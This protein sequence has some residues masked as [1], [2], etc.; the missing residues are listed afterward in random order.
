MSP[1]IR[2]YFPLTPAQVAQLSDEGRIDAGLVGFAVDDSIRAGD[3]DGDA[4]LWEFLSL[5]RAAAHA[6]SAGG[7]VVVAA[8]DVSSSTVI[9]SPGQELG[10]ALNGPLAIAG[11]VCIHLGDDALALGAGGIEALSQRPDPVSGEH[12]DLSWFDISEMA[13]VV[14]HLSSPE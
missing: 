2:M 14:R 5:Q 8:A 10:A 4:E 1:E 12:I 9:P 6:H 13:Q 11:V 7:P 3:P